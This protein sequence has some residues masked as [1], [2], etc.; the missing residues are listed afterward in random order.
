[1]SQ[2]TPAHHWDCHWVCTRAWEL[3]AGNFGWLRLCCRDRGSAARLS[4][5]NTCPI[6]VPHTNLF[7]PSLPCDRKTTFLSGKS[8]FSLSRLFTVTAALALQAAAALGDLGRTLLSRR[9]EEE[10][11][12]VSPG[13]PAALHPPTLPLS[14]VV[15]P[16]V[17][18]PWRSGCHR[19]T[20]ALRLPLH[21]LAPALSQPTSIINVLIRVSVPRPWEGA[22]AP[23]C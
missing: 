4:R 11:C 20:P 21:P 9:S 14:Q 3:N 12:L 23:R 6:C 16:S 8:L 15:S 10:P 13:S 2:D 17:Q 22:L 5:H 18:P 1:M 19:P 7:S